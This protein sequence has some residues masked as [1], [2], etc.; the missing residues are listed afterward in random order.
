MVD[1]KTQKAVLEV[2]NKMQDLIGS[3]R[4]D[5]ARNLARIYPKVGGVM[6]A[7]LN[8]QKST[9]NIPDPDGRIAQILEVL[10]GLDEGGLA[11]TPED[12]AVVIR[13]NIPDD[14]QFRFDKNY[15]QMKGGAWILWRLGDPW[16]MDFWARGIVCPQDES[17]AIFPLP[18]LAFGENGPNA[19]LGCEY[20]GP[21]NP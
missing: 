12:K 17:Q 15:R 2:I 5:E 4:Y 8:V 21:F 3:G 19:I 14:M 6:A 1:E 10:M 7:R 20:Y 18:K 16:N 9:T 11:K 13:R